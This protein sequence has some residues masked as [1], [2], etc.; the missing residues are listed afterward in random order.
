MY[1]EWLYKMEYVC[2]IPQG[3]GMEQVLSQLEFKILFGVS[4]FYDDDD[5]TEA[6]TMMDAVYEVDSDDD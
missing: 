4:T 5:D 1:L 3:I 6:D 2:R